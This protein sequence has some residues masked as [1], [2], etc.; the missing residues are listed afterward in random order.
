MNVGRLACGLDGVVSEGTS[1]GEEKERMTK[2]RM[3]GLALF[4]AKE[5]EDAAVRVVLMAPW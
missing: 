5:D 1:E 3:W 2:K 4:S